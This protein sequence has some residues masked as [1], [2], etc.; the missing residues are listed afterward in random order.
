MKIY[1]LSFFF[2][3]SFFSVFMLGVAFGFSSR[4]ASI[5]TA[6]PDLKEKR[7]FFIPDSEMKCTCVPCLPDL[8]CLKCG[9]KSRDCPKLSY[10]FHSS[11]NGFSSLKK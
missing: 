2:G 3:L 1:L 4:F 11:T 7:S 10:Y 5:R 8:F 9:H 6:Q